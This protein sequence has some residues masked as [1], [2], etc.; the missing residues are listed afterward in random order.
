[1]SFKITGTGSY[2]PERVVTNDEMSSIVDT[3]DEWIVQRTGVH[4]RHISET[5]SAADMG[6]HAARAALENAGVRPEEL[7]LIIAASVSSDDMCPG[8]AQMTQRFI[9]ATCPAF[10]ISAACSG[11]IYL[12]DTAAGFIAR[13]YRHV[14]V[15][16]AE[17][18]SR[19]IDWED[20]STCVL[21]G[22]A[23]G[24]LV[25]EPG[26]NYLDSIL[27]AYGGDEVIKIP[28]SRGNSPFWKGEL[29]PDPFALMDG[30]ETFKFAVN[31]F[32]K[33][34]D[35]VL[36]RNGFV[37]GDVSW[38]I[39]HQANLRIIDSARRRL[40]GIPEER[41]AVNI[42][43]YGNTSAACIPLLLDELNRQGKLHEN[44]LVILVAFG[45]GLTSGACLIRW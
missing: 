29:P 22:D 23:A 14:L 8:V 24:A 39:P 31:E 6:A 45:G 4:T 18:M 5:E 2:V 38:V 20:R 17:R 13:G 33:D 32:I 12:L 34:I 35:T 28:A 27:C 15:I 16:G 30:P 44:D 40:K 9:G 37:Q 11:F 25:L 41:F 36:K 43:E 42:G 26:D 3:S 21:F 10:D 1:M 7:D 19:I